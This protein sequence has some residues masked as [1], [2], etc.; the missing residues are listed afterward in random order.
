MEDNKFKTWSDLKS[1]LTYKT[2]HEKKVISEMARMVNAI[3]KRRKELGLTQREV[4]ERAGVTQAQIARL[5]TS[6]SVPSIETVIKVGMALG[7]TVGFKESA[8]EQAASKL[9]YA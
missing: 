8:D 6:T 1:K 3:V 7:L 5:E 2:D 4:A 9:V